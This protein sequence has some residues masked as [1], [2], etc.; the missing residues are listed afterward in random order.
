MVGPEV[1]LAAAFRVEVQR[2]RCRCPLVI[3]AGVG[4]CCPNL[5]VEVVD[6]PRLVGIGDSQE[7]ENRL[8]LPEARTFLRLPAQVDI[9]TNRLTAAV[10]PLV[11]PRNSHS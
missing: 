5:R 1:R 6:L 10:G 7:V 2:I 9:F 3:I 4:A 8:R 11:N